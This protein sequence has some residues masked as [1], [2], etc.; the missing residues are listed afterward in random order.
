MSTNAGQQPL[1][2]VADFNGD[3]QVDMSDFEDISS[4]YDSETGDEQY[5]IL[6]DLNADGAINEDDLVQ[7]MD[8]IGKDVPL[9]DQQ[10]AQA[11]QA[12]MKYY[13]PGGL[14]QAIAD[15]YLPN[16]PEVKGHG[17]HYA[18]LGIFLA[19]KNLEQTNL[20]LPV[21]L[22]YD[23]EGNLLAVYYLREPI[24][25]EATPENPLAALLIDQ[26]ND[27]P[28]DS[29]DGLSAE[30]WHQH[31]SIW[32]TNAGSL[33]SEA[34]YYDEFVPID[35]IVSRIEAANFQFFPESDKF[36]TPK[37]WMLHGWFHSFN[38]NGTFAIT[39]PDVALYAPEELGVH[40]GHNSGSS[41]PFIGGT[42]AGEGL[43]G[44]D[45]DDR[46]NGFDGDDWILGGLGDDSIW[47]SHG[48]DWIR[49]DDDNS[50]EG[51]DDMLYGGPGQD[52]IWGNVGDDRLF[53]GTEDDR[54]HGEEGD[55]LIRGGLG[56]D[57]LTGGEGL[58]DFV[59]V[60]GEG[61][62]I[63]TDLELEFD[64]IVLY[65]GITTETISIEQLNSDTAISF[66]NENLA[67]LGG[68]NADDLLAASAD[69][70]LVA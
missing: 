33:D 59:L 57:I 1:L 27:F 30:D 37:V 8:D 47:G 48:N 43:F 49:G 29:F 15:G 2:T 45:E 40:G 6:Y 13:G 36:Y 65:G 11:T 68:V 34:V 24:T 3:G 56:Y 69:V 31:Q 28:P 58:D 60:A 17:I 14:E 7:T 50:S 35:A 53:G 39:N 42:D 67:I 23:A 54:L 21:G 44:T 46:L 10:I 12:T 4:R 18:N 62:D 26:N 66:N 19:T 70:F 64:T 55:D 5:H 63:I 61:T 32:I 16:I 41:T 25:Q 38:S 20:N 9:L 22:N 51:G 52:L